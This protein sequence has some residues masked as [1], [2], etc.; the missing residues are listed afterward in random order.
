MLF[1]VVDAETRFK[2][3]PVIDIVVYRGGDMA[4]AWLYTAM[5]ATLGL[6]LAGVAIFSAFVCAAWAAAG[7]YLGRS[8]QRRS[9]TDKQLPE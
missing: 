7:A 4:T 5:T 6:G 9:T 2:A 1:T 3:K 8:Y